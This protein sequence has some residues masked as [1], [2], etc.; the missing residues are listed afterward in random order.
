MSTTEFKKQMSDRLAKLNK[1]LGK[2][3]KDLSSFGY[4]EQVKAIEFVY[5]SDSLSERFPLQIF[6]M[7][8]DR[9]EVIIDGKIFKTSAIS[10]DLAIE[11]PLFN[12][13]ELEAY[14]EQDVDCFEASTEVFIN[15]FIGIWKEAKDSKFGR[16]TG[17]I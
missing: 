2:Q 17:K 8:A 14:D 1:S 12:L 10:I 3:L 4:P 13:D 9:N 6:F 5:F 7:D 11:R 16:W 15:W